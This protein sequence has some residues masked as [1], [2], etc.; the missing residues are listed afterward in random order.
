M[1]LSHSSVWVRGAAGYAFRET[2]QPFADFFFGAFGNNWIDHGDEK[3]YRQSYAFPGLD[4]NAIGGRSFLKSTLEWNLPPLRF[5][6]LG[7]PG[8]YVAWLRPAVFAGGLGI[9]AGNASTRRFVTNAGG[10]IDLRIMVLSELEM[11]LSVGGAV[12]FEKDGRTSRE[13]MISLKILR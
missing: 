8:A 12:A 4:L 5:S 13:G 7:T 1:P 11:T 2:D 6:R 3:R 9:G 10:Q